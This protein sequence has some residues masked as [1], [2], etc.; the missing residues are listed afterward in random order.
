MNAAATNG[1]GCFSLVEC[2]PALTENAVG[3]TGKSFQLKPL[4]LLFPRPETRTMLSSSPVRQRPEYAG[5]SAEMT[6]S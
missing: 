5:L 1:K 2:I 4:E 6:I 3:G